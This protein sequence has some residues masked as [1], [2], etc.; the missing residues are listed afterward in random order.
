MKHLT[1]KP[2]N[3][4]VE[5]QLDIFRKE[6]NFS[7]EELLYFNLKAKG[8]TVVQICMKMMIS[9]KKMYDIKNAVEEKMM[10]VE[11]KFLK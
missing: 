5:Y 11:D 1:E 6:C 7:E 9:Q 2:I 10:I 3:K 8:L 4:Y